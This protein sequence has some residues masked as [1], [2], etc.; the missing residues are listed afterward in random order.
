MFR[1]KVDFAEA[2]TALDGATKIWCYKVDA[3][4]NE[5]CQITKGRKH[6]K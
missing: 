4:Y 1:A 5:A 2:A 6:T 3:I